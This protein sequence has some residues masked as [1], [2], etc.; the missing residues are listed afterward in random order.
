MS[1]SQKRWKGAC[2]GCGG[3]G[4]DDCMWEGTEEARQWLKNAKAE[5]MAIADALYGK[6]TPGEKGEHE[7]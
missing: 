5:C 1:E 2:S 6:P 7:G 4:C 3:R